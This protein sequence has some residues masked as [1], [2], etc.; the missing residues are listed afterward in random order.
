MMK[1]YLTFFIFI[2]FIFST[3]GQ[4]NEFIKIK[5]V[6]FS[7]VELPPKCGREPF[8]VTLKFELLENLDSI[9]KGENIL[10]K[11]LCPSDTGVENFIDNNHFKFSSYSDKEEIK[12]L[13]KDWIV[14][15]VYENENLPTFWAIKIENL[16]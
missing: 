11:I 1:Y 4:T 15:N 14:W 9:N 12:M 8:G 3:F 6:D 7:S 13:E 2:S 16:E 10:V 5:L